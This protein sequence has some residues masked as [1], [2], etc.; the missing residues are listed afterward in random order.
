MILVSIGHHPYRKGACYKNFCEFDEAKIWQAL[1]CHYLGEHG[2]GVPTGVLKEKIDFINAQPDATLAVEIHFNAA[3]KWVDKDGDGVYDEGEDVHVGKGCETLY[4]PN[5]EKGKLAA[6][7]VQ[8]KLSTIFEPD[9][10]AKEGWYKMNKA[11]G[12]DMFLKRTKCT[13]LIIEPEFIH[14]KELIQ[15]NRHEACVVIANALLVI[16]D[17][18]KSKKG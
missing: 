7:I 15:K 13:S 16:N 18:F 14:R 9:R 12:A 8:D 11:N 2:L 1:I 5:S 17:M 3:V 10:G 6:H 4:Y